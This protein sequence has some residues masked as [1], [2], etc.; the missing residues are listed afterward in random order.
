M[1]EITMNSVNNFNVAE[2]KFELNKRGLST[3]GKKT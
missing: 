2:L 3:Q 1:S